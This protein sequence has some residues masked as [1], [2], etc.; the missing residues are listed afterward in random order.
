MKIC[1]VFAFSAILPFLLSC[2]IYAPLT[3]NSS[4]EDRLEEAQKCLHD[5]DLACAVRN[6]EL[7]SDARQKNERL[8]MTYLSQA[9]FTL[10]ALINI[11][12]AGGSTMLGKLAGALIPFSQTKL[13]AAVSAKTSCQ[14]YFANPIST[15]LSVLLKTMAYLND[16]A[17]R[18][19]RADAF[20]AIDETDTTCSTT[21]GNGDG[22]ST[23]ADVGSS[24][25]ALS[26]G[27]PGMC[28]PDVDLCLAD[29]TAISSSQ[30]TGSGFGD[31][32]GAYDSLP[33]ELKNSSAAT[34]A[35][36]NAL[37]DTLPN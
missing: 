1:L 21:A 25:G 5:A 2:N 8:C 3:T 31:L 23:K 10:P 20:V 4:D 32:K 29:I 17:I 30:L 9:G 12:N 22:V 18:I 36:R 16:C 27:T 33:S 13:D 24:G 35:V 14:D 15:D 7:L 26:A 19:A 6:Y 37:R 28:K 11:V 34:A